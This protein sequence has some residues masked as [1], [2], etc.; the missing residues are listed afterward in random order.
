VGEEDEILI[1]VFFRCLDAAKEYINDNLATMSEF[2]TQHQS[3]SKR[4][5]N[6]FIMPLQLFPMI[7]TDLDRLNDIKRRHGIP[8]TESTAHALKIVSSVFGLEVPRPVGPLVELVGPIFSTEYQGL[9]ETFAT[10]LSQHSNVVYV[11]FGQHASPSEQDVTRVLTPLVHQYEKGHIDGIIWSSGN[12]R[13]EKFPA[14]LTS[15]Y[16]GKT[17]DLAALFDSSNTQKTDSLGGDLFVTRWSPQMAV[18]LH[19]SVSVF[20]SHG[21]AN[22]LIESLHAQKRLIFFPFFGDQPGKGKSSRFFF[23]GLIP[24]FCL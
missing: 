7:K 9:D 10:Y 3:I 22:S 6:K 4:L 18:L 11:A 23:M 14:T 17:Y 1:P 19:P 21:G 24:F 15:A 16:S 8:S 12:A 20:V 5:Y 2:T 13:K